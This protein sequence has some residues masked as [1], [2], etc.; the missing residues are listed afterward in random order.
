[1]NHSVLGP[2]YRGHW[3]EEETYEEEEEEKVSPESDPKEDDEMEGD[4]QINANEEET[5][6]LPPAGEMEQDILLGQGEPEGDAG[7][8]AFPGPR[9]PVP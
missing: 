6:V 7:E 4:L 5:F 8:K 1:M 2:V 3:S 9:K